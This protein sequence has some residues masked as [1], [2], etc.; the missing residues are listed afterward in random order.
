MFLSLCSA[1]QNSI[2]Q[3]MNTTCCTRRTEKHMVQISQKEYG[4]L[5]LNVTYEHIGGCL[6]VGRRF[7]RKWGT[8][9][10]SRNSVLKT[11]DLKC[12]KGCAK[13]RFL[14]LGSLTF[15]VRIQYNIILPQAIVLV[16]YYKETFNDKIRELRSPQLHYRKW[17]SIFC[18]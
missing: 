2:C 8:C 3:P 4:E 18:I 15:S 13:E 6:T 5:L 17:F 11:C 14:S 16:C 7:Y 10:P 1:P 12:P 9:A